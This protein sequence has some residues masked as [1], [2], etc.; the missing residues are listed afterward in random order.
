MASIETRFCKWLNN[1]KRD[2]E[3]KNAIDYLNQ[4]YRRWK[5]ELGYSFYIN[6]VTDLVYFFVKKEKLNIDDKKRLMSKLPPMVE[7]F[8][9]ITVNTY[10]KGF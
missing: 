10:K 4:A 2:P 1:N 8:K 3:V 9:K 7:C 5:D 6:C